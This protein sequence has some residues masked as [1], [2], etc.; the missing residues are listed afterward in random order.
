MS[1]RGETDGFAVVWS[2]KA[3]RACSAWGVMQ[4]VTASAAH[5]RP[6]PP[7]DGNVAH[8][9]RLPRGAEGI[10]TTVPPFNELF[11]V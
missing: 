9:S 4:Q 10:R 2:N 8:L 7:T 5:Q 6:P 1:L 3:G 11:V